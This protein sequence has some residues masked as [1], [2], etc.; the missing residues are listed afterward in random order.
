MLAS[1]GSESVVCTLPTV[2]I[3]PRASPSVLSQPV[4]EL[5]VVCCDINYANVDDAVAVLQS[6]FCSVANVVFS[7]V[8]VPSAEVVKKAFLQALLCPSVTTVELHLSTEAR[9]RSGGAAGV[10]DVLLSLFGVCEREYGGGGGRVSTVILD[11][12]EP[13]DND[14][15]RS[16]CALS[17]VRQLYV[18]CR[19]NRSR[20]MKHVPQMVRDAT[21][22]QLL[23]VT[24]H[25][26]SKGSRVCGGVTCSRRD[27]TWEL[28]E[29]A[30]DEADDE[31]ELV[32]RPPAPAD[33]PPPLPHRRS[34]VRMVAE[35]AGGAV[36]EDAD[37]ARI[38]AAADDV[39]GWAA[40][41]DR[42]TGV[43]RVQSAAGRARPAVV[44][45]SGSKVV[46][47]RCDFAGVDVHVRS[48]YELRGCSFR[49]CSCT[50][51]GG[52]VVG[53]TLLH[54]AVSAAAGSVFARNT[55]VAGCRSPLTT[56]ASTLPRG[57]QNVVVVV[58]GGEACID[59]GYEPC[60]AVRWAQPEEEAVG[61]RTKVFAGPGRAEGL[62]L[63]LQVERHAALRSSGCAVVAG[64]EYGHD[65]ARF[66]AYYD[67][68][69]TSLQAWV[70][71]RHRSQLRSDAL[72][73][74]EDALHAYHSGGL[75]HGCA[76]AENVYVEDGRLLL[77]PG[78]PAAWEQSADLRE[79]ARVIGMVQGL[80]YG[81]AAMERE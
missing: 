49:G 17:T 43:L 25:Y 26:S 6:P 77:G 42:A 62:L 8:S 14:H 40:G 19:A 33:P 30:A 68:P 37:V 56:G 64:A 44:L 36:A 51:D 61:P 80:L 22:V 79:L 48:G 59:R 23:R 52:A 57:P 31:L 55:V 71:D 75:A 65:G 34:C 11:T 38:T 74:L 73:N 78:T 28:A 35:A 4:T 50:V 70:S 60:P 54:T 7:E 39:R 27:G 47:Q 72:T 58:G 46:L 63:V 10:F 2:T 76:L 1:C 69:R 9:E 53:C 29:A 41:S 21:D 45:E 15:F 66:C 13:I 24:L 32:R 12:K 20:A 5:Q 81:A 3:P 18:V 16:V 67:Q